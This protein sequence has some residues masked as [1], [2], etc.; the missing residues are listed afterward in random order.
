MGLGINIGFGKS[1]KII[2]KMRRI[3]KKLF[4]WSSIKKEFNDNNDNWEH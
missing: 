3:I 1:S 4:F 2:Q